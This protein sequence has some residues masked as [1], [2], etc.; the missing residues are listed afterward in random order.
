M[1]GRGKGRRRGGAAHK[2]RNHYFRT[3]PTC[4]IESETMQDTKRRSFLMPPLVLVRD[5]C[6]RSDWEKQSREATLTVTTGMSEEAVVATQG[7]WW[8]EAAASRPAI[9]QVL[10]VVKT[11]TAGRQAGGSHSQPTT[12]SLDTLATFTH[13]HLPFHPLRTT[14]SCPCSSPFLPFNL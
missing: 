5:G 9:C 6:R 10:C 1:N 12:A 8:P 4:V 2:T 7:F 14:E 3:L 13:C 11:Q